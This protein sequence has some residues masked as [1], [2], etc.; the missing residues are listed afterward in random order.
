MANCTMLCLASSSPGFPA[1]DLPYPKGEVGAGFV[2]VSSPY[3][4]NEGQPFL[5]L[6][7]GHLLGQWVRFW[8][9]QLVQQQQKGLIWVL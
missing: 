5:R 6:P 7:M 3:L 2:E 9:R 4:E 1:H 8:L